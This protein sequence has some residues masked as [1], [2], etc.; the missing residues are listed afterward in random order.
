[1]TVENFGFGFASEEEAALFGL[2]NLAELDGST[3]EISVVNLGSYTQ[4]DPGLCFRLQ[5]D[6]D[7]GRS[8]SDPQG[9]IAT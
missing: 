7:H 8:H 4:I 2:H 9:P 5:P 1:M 3:P 6:P